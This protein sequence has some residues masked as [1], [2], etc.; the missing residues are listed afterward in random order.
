MILT[1]GKMLRKLKTLKNNI[2]Y[3]DQ[4]KQFRMLFIDPL[5]YLPS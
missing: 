4:D 1:Q 3:Q 2:Q 5:L